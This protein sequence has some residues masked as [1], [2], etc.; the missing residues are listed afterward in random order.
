MGIFDYDHVLAS[1]AAM[2]CCEKLLGVLYGEQDEFKQIGK[3]GY[4]NGQVEDWTAGGQALT[5]RKGKQQ[6]LT[7]RHPIEFYDELF[8]W[9]TRLRAVEVEAKLSELVMAANDLSDLC[10]DGCFGVWFS[11]SSCYDR[12]KKVQGSSYLVLA[13]MCMAAG[14]RVPA[15]LK[16]AFVAAAESELARSKDFG[17]PSGSVAVTLRKKII[18]AIRGHDFDDPK[19]RIFVRECFG[20]RELHAL[21]KLKARGVPDESEEDW[22]PWFPFHSCA[23][24]TTHVP[25]VAAPGIPRARLSPWAD[26]QTLYSMTEGEAPPRRTYAPPPISE[27]STPPPLH[28]EIRAIGKSPSPAAV[29]SAIHDKDRAC[30][31][32]GKV[33]EK[34]STFSKCARCK[35]VAYCDADCQKAH[36]SR[37]KRECKELAAMIKEMQKKAPGSVPRKC[38]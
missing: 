13:L 25:I 23:S 22:D 35:T 31:Y 17:A 10:G 34:G 30:A 27:R 26:T 16:D 32:C 29:R 36:W 15:P 2:E 7:F 1:D 5:R 11:D 38:T 37:H 6:I 4:I 9:W 18:K 28:F 14:A 3:M 12:I 24:L 8:K 19:H 20:P 21:A 33:A